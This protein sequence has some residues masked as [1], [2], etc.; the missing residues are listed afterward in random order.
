MCSAQKTQDNGY[1][2]FR[3]RRGSPLNSTVSVTG[4]KLLVIHLLI[5]QIFVE[6]FLYVGHC[7]RH[8]EGS[9]EQVHT[10][11]GLFSSG[12]IPGV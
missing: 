5:Q 2:H 6:H 11:M 10:L 9:S 4:A 7:F 12:E 3:G 1:F 8:E